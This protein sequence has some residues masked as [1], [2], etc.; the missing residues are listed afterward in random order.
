M[1]PEEPVASGESVLRRFSRFID[2]SRLNVTGIRGADQGSSRNSYVRWAKGTVVPN[3]EGAA[4]AA[5]NI[6]AAAKARP[7]SPKHKEFF[8]NV[9]RW[10]PGSNPEGTAEEF[11]EL[12]RDLLANVPRKRRPRRPRVDGPAKGVTVVGELEEGRGDDHSLQGGDRD[13][14]PTHEGQPDSAGQTESAHVLRDGPRS[15]RATP[16]KPS[17]SCGSWLSVPWI[18]WDPNRDG[19]STLLRPESRVV[20]FHG[21]HRKAEILELSRWCHEGARVGFRAY[22]GPGG[23]GKTRLGLQLCDEL[24]AS[25]GSEWTVGFMNDRSLCTDRSPWV[26]MSLVDR[27]LLVVVDYAADQNKTEKILHLLRNLDSCPAS[28]I[29]ILFLEREHLWLGRLFEDADARRALDKACFERDQL[30]IRLPPVAALV[31]D[32]KNSYQLAATQFAARLKVVDVGATELDLSAAAYDQVLLLH[33]QAL[34]RTSGFKVADRTSAI[35]NGLLARERKYWKRLASAR[36]LDWSLLPAIEQACYAISSAGGVESV[37]AGVG[38]CLEHPFLSDL[39]RVVVFGI[40][41]LLRECYP[42]D[43]VG[44]G[45]LQPDLLAQQLGARAARRS[46]QGSA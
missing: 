9:K 8:N 14:Y 20:P 19:P 17:S 36:G 15:I 23:I 12:I 4:L 33:T 2:W 7:E 22:E 21:K 34:L 38:L 46:L 40:V 5:G 13:K 45:P 27:P 31:A 26:E 42:T 1:P 16:G 35:L 18:D 32:R 43:G 29:R 24:K 37:E 30:D 11:A 39:P 44:I 28:Q 25:E 10:F 6:W 41:D 3:T